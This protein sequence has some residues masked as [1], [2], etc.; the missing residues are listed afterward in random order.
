MYLRYF[1]CGEVNE[2]WKLAS[3]ILNGEMKENHKWCI[4]YNNHCNLCEDSQK[5]QSEGSYRFT[6]WKQEG[7]KFV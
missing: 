2:W 1:Y 5:Q 3:L 4:P 6:A 7:G